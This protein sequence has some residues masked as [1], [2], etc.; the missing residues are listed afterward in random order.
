[1]RP[2]LTTFICVFV[3]LASLPG[4]L[5]GDVAQDVLPKI[6]AD[7]AC[8][9]HMPCCAASAPSEPVKPAPVLPSSRA[10]HEEWQ[11]VPTKPIEISWSRLVTPVNQVIAQ[12]V[13]DPALLTVTVP[14]FVR[15]CSSLT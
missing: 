12:A 15:H 1:M 11:S 2:F 8:S 5:L 14:L 7:A 13:N 3:T 6:S 9:C 4:W 10:Q